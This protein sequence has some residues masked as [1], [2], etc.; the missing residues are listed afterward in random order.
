MHA[1][2][3][4]CPKIL[5]SEVYRLQHLNQVPWKEGQE[6]VVFRDSRMDINNGLSRA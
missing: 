1:S 2:T 5:R 3:S 4:P 6:E